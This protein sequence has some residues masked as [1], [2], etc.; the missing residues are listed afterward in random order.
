MCSYSYYF[1]SILFSVGNKL[2]A[3][4]EFPLKYSE[5]FAQFLVIPSPFFG[6]K[7]CSSVFSCCVLSVVSIL[8]SQE[9][10]N[11]TKK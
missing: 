5:L 1:R 11:V 8:M 7:R 9:E 4:Q 6:E 10:M 3:L 2:A